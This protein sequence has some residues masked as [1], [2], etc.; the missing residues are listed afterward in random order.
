MNPNENISPEE[1]LLRLIKGQSKRERPAQEI[2]PAQVGRDLFTQP[3]KAI[4]GLALRPVIRKA[5]VNRLTLF[6][7]LNFWLFI[8]WC[9][10][11]LLVLVFIKKTAGG[12]GWVGSE[13]TGI[14][15]QKESAEVKEKFPGQPVSH[16]LDIVARH[17]LFKIYEGP[18]KS[19]G[20][21]PVKAGA[22]ELLSN[23]SLAGI[24]S[25][26]NPQAII[27]DKKSK[28]TYFLNQGQYL[29]DFKIEEILEGKVIL[30]L[31]GQRFELSL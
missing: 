26:E 4:A 27:E 12:L 3:P 10:L 28:N 19:D 15:S 25:G 29:G 18:A 30:E 7:R 22:S 23:Y 17:N 1:R 11:I 31:K 9:V 24:V 14:A 2:K 6:E 5:A 21:I 8:F 16:Y 13:I 20:H